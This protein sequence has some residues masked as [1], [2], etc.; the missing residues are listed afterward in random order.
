MRRPAVGFD[1]PGAI[2]YHQ[3]YLVKQGQL[4]EAAARA[5]PS[6]T[7]C[8]DAQRLRLGLAAMPHPSG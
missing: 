7:A 1:G 8:T 5:E 3:Q 4:C 2:R 6:N